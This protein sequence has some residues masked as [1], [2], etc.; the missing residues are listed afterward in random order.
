MPTLP[1]APPETVASVEDA[2]AVFKAFLDRLATAANENGY[3]EQYRILMDRAARSLPGI[4]EVQD[5]VQPVAGQVVIS[6]RVRFPS[7]EPTGSEANLRDRA[8]D[9]INTWAT[10]NG[11]GNDRDHLKYLHYLIAHID[12]IDVDDRDYSQGYLDRYSIQQPGRR[13]LNRRVEFVTD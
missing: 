13:T 2:A 11:H 5:E 6:A 1:A 12:D 10:A 8:T 4:R 3:I 7:I 9:E